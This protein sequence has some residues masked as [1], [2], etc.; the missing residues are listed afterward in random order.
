MEL[1]NWSC[2]LWDSAPTLKNTS[3]E[4]QEFELLEK[5][6]QILDLQNE[7]AILKSDISVLE[8]KTLS[9]G[10]SL[11]TK[12]AKIISLENSLHAEKAKFS[13]SVKTESTI[14]AAK[15][16]KKA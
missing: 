11:K 3:A 15:S 14:C 16:M 10:N 8:A 4:S 9:L 1:D 6:K 5:E 7:K 2:F 12:K 13:D